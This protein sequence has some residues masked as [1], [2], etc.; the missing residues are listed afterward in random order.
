MITAAATRGISISEFGNLTNEE[1]NKI[2][3]VKNGL[4]DLNLIV[5][6]IEE[7]YRLMAEPDITQKEIDRHR[8]RLRSLE[9]LLAEINGRVNEAMKK[10]QDISKLS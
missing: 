8:L 4:E 2:L 9:K 10:N 6:E 7:T 3:L 1:M 5:Q